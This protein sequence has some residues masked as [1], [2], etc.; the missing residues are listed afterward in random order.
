MS[1]L[2]ASLNRLGESKISY[3]LEHNREEAIMVLIA[4]PGQRWEVEFLS[5]GSV[6]VE[7]FTSDSCFALMGHIGA[8]FEHPNPAGWRDEASVSLSS[9]NRWP[10]QEH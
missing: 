5:D 7:V 6:E 3:R 1:Q 9:R 2:L 8:G 10:D 4:V